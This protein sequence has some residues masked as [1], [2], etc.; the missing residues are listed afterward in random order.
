MPVRSF[1]LN[2]QSFAPQGRKGPGRIE[3]DAPMVTMGDKFGKKKKG[4]KVKAN[5]PNENAIKARKNHIK[6]NN[7]KNK[8]KNEKTKQSHPVHHPSHVH[9]VTKGV[10][11]NHLH[12]D[13]GHHVTEHHV[14]NG[15]RTPM[16][17]IMSLIRDRFEMEKVDKHFLISSKNIKQ[18]RELFDKI[19]G[20]F[21]NK[22]IDTRRRLDLACRIAA[23]TMTKCIGILQMAKF[24]ELR[25][26]I[27]K[28]LASKSSKGMGE[29]KD[30]Y[31]IVMQS[32]NEKMKKEFYDTT[33]GMSADGLLD[34]ERNIDKLGVFWEKSYMTFLRGM[35]YNS[36]REIRTF[37]AV[38]EFLNYQF[39][40]TDCEKKSE[41]E[42]YHHWVE[43]QEGFKTSYL[44][45][46]CEKTEK[47]VE[48]DECN[49]DLKRRVQLDAVGQCM[50]DLLITEYCR[51]HNLVLKC[52]ATVGK[53]TFTSHATNNMLHTYNHA[54]MSLLHDKHWDKAAT[55]EKL[56]TG[57]AQIYDCVTNWNTNIL[58]T[59][60]KAL[61]AKVGEDFDENENKTPITLYKALGDLATSGESHGSGTLIMSSLLHGIVP[62]R[63][64]NQQH[65]QLPKEQHNNL[66]EHAPV[67]HDKFTKA[68]I[69]NLDFVGY[70]AK[71]KMNNNRL[72][73][74]GKDIMQMIKAFKS[75]NNERKSFTKE[76]AALV[77]YA[78]GAFAWPVAIDAN[79]FNTDLRTS[80]IDTIQK[81]LDDEM[82][83]A[84]AA[85][86]GYSQKGSDKRLVAAKAHNVMSIINQL[87]KTTGKYNDQIKLEFFHKVEQAEKSQNNEI[88]YGDLTLLMM[89]ELYGRPQLDAT[90]YSGN[91]ITEAYNL[92]LKN[93]N[94]RTIDACLTQKVEGF[95]ML[96]GTAVQQQ[97]ITAAAIAQINQQQAEFE[98]ARQLAQEQNQQ[99]QSNAQQLAASNAYQEA[100][101][102]YQNAW[103]AYDAYT[104]T[105]SP[106]AVEAYKLARTQYEAAKN[107]FDT[108]KYL[109]EIATNNEAKMSAYE[110]A[111]KAAGKMKWAA[112]V[113]KDQA[114]A[115]GGDGAVEEAAENAADVAEKEMGE[116]LKIVK[117][118]GSLPDANPKRGRE[119]TREDTQGLVA[120]RT[121]TQSPLPN[122]IAFGVQEHVP[123]DQPDENDKKVFN[124]NNI[125]NIIF[126]PICDRSDF[127]KYAGADVSHY[128]SLRYAEHHEF[129]ENPNYIKPDLNKLDST[130]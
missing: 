49:H 22:R 105:A 29:S 31:E 79:A 65:L 87:C 102:A 69:A 88:R 41:Q 35:I 61:G 120:Q 125:P 19:P 115:A 72:L 129:T 9:L 13:Y 107:M 104:K 108:S 90:Y 8:K 112:K 117:A 60:G 64:Q 43:E 25:V 6:K 40:S 78:Y 4:G 121:G 114:R 50:Y 46:A 51:M 86:Q 100:A 85:I 70:F 98:R 56:Y 123:A 3:T 15:A 12:H 124:L 74:H 110:D 38:L 33:K 42:F 128:R 94:F 18:S 75:P 27:V 68:L 96:L 48:H 67:Q 80:Y 47:Q 30:F 2:M 23:N 83:K 16:S 36:A 59:W 73:T 71:Q 26:N 21:Y 24:N 20:H 127:L 118:G 130:C 1:D 99:A 53:Y 97:A 66:P 81:T 62:T 122:S 11:E 76:Q 55:V 111:E 52:I 95:P 82:E 37:N 119:K 39:L 28:G 116:Q 54:M 17:Y 32:L 45:P 10:H 92:H 91:F 57:L 113:S 34:I 63:M 106:L 103:E 5:H 84:K 101:V 7:A 126:K 14:Y 77:A 58:T 89:Y 44:N 109:A 93:I